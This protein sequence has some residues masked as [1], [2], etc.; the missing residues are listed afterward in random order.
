MP[1]TTTRS[2]SLISNETLEDAAYITANVLEVIEGVTKSTA[3]IALANFPYPDVYA[4][5]I[6][7]ASL[8][9][10]SAFSNGAKTSIRAKISEYHKKKAGGVAQPASLDDESHGSTSETLRPIQH[11][12]VTNFELGYLAFSKKLWD[13][14]ATG[15][16]YLEV[17]GQYIAPVLT[18]YAMTLPDGDPYKEHV[19]SAGYGLSSSSALC[20]FY[21]IL[22]QNQS[23]NRGQERLTLEETPDV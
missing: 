11:N 21:R 22:A 17:C 10:T 12:T 14:T 23:Q 20:Y 19:L 1:V 15:L 9:L 2:A 3:L 6:A 8:S 18:S 16:G 4:L 7:A 13:V 5:Q